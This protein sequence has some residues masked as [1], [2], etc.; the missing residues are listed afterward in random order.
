MV[1]WPQLHAADPSL[2]TAAASAYRKLG[3]DYVEQKSELDGVARYFSGWRGQGSA[4]VPNL[5]YRHSELLT[6]QATRATTA[7]NA[8]TE[9]AGEIKSAKNMLRE[10]LAD[11]ERIPAHVSAD[12]TVTP[13]KFGRGG[14]DPAVAAK[15]AADAIA[16]AV[17]KAEQADGAAQSKL[18]AITDR[19]AGK[20]AAPRASIPLK[21]APKDV[22]AWWTGMSDAERQAY[23]MLHPEVIGGLDGVPVADRDQ[24]NRLVLNDQLSKMKAKVAAL[25]ARGEEDEQLTK[26]YQALKFIDK[27]LDTVPPGGDPERQRAYLIGLDTAGKG[28]AIVSIGNPDDADN[29][30]TY[31]PGTTAR[32]GKIQG[33][34]N[35]MDVT[36]ADTMAMDPT[37]KTAGI[38]W[39]NYEAPSTFVN[40]RETKYAVNA[41]KALDRFQEGLRSTHYGT[42]PARHTMIGHSYGS[43]TIGYAAKHSLKDGTPIAT[44]RMVF[45]GSPGVG[46]DHA[47]DLGIGAQNV[48]ASRAKGDIIRVTGYKDGFQGKKYHFGTNPA[49]HDFGGRG[50]KSVPVANKIT[51]GVANHSGYWHEANREYARWNMSLV[52]LGMD[53][54]VDD[55]YEGE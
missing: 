16:D 32:L 39:L 48:F 12:G 41:A 9:L 47:R 6:E 21:A 11:A 23:I 4:A 46:V 19:E 13:T 44:D 17:R 33:D 2:Y 50:F 24:A 42:T 53:H 55:M 43:T 36:V 3:N 14:T 5:L 52:I 37:K 54:E 7:A 20:S 27:R 8:L 28:R 18:E 10:A 30:V 38:M 51:G 40:A 34:I 35:R 49:H 31:V 22:N 29:V 26:D 15:R 1:T 45:V 25:D